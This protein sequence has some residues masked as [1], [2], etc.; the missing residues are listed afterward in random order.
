MCGGDEHKLLNERKRHRVP[1]SSA[2]VKGTMYKGEG[3]GESQSTEQRENAGDDFPG[4]D[5]APE[6]SRLPHSVT[7]GAG[8][9]T[10][11]RELKRQRRGQS[12][13]FP[14]LQCMCMLSITNP[15]P[16]T[17][18]VTPGCSCSN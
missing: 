18:A 2:S 11:L 14:H 15:T 13:S 7:R 1:R 10:I 4:V 8:R 5:H 17:E 12:F 16:A 3:S 6:D 9:I